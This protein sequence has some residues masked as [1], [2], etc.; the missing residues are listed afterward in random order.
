MKKSIYQAI[1]GSLKTIA[2][3]I[4]SNIRNLA[5]CQKSV[6]HTKKVVDPKN[7]GPLEESP[8]FHLSLHDN[9]G[10]SQV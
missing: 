7:L 4:K 1:I 2:N 5:K 3:D 8:F 9:E 10:L 6:N